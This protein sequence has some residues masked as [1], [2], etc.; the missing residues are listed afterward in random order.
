MLFNSF[1]FLLFLPI[2]YVGYWMLSRRAQ[3]WFL[4]SASYVFY[5]WWDWRFLGLIVLS[6]AVD[7]FVGLR[8]A[9]EERLSA[10]ARPC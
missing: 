1:A 3:N 10:R 9:A 2:V 7:Y 4:L 8:M 6:S 5:G